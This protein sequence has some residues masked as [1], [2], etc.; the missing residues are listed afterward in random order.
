MPTPKTVTTENVLP[1]PS[2]PAGW[3]PDPSGVPHLRYFDG[4]RW[5]D[6]L[7]PMGLP[8]QPRQDLGPGSALHYIVPVGRS[9]QAVLS[10]WLGLFALLPF[11][12]LLFALAAIGI[13]TW[14]LVRAGSGGHGV[15]RCVLAIIF[16][17]LGLLWLLLLIN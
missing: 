9:W 5:T 17:I 10:P 6:Q 12:G 15:G 16:G 11:I 8:Q 14:G 2:T 3:Y 13:G 4:T 7:A 1:L